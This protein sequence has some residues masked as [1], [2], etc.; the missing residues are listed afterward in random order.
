MYAKRRSAVSR[1]QVPSRASGQTHP[2]H[3]APRLPGATPNSDAAESVAV[4]GQ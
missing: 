4:K 2:C 1:L 3:Y